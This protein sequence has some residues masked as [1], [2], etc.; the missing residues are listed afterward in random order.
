MDESSALAFRVALQTY[1]QTNHP[2]DTEKLMMIFLRFQMYREI[3]EYTEQR[4][5]LSSC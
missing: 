1:L 4:V 5:T 3:A 2:D